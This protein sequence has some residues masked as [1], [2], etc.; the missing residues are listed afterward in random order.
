MNYRVVIIIFIIISICIIK[1]F[2]TIETFN[3]YNKPDP[4]R[5]VVLERTTTTETTTTETLSTYDGDFVVRFTGIKFASL[6]TPNDEYI[7]GDVFI[8]NLSIRNIDFM[9]V[10][11]RI[12]GDLNIDNNSELTN[13]DGL[14]N[15][16]YIGGS[17]NIHSNGE[18]GN[19]VPQNIFDATENCIA[20]CTPQT[21]STPH[22]SRQMFMCWTDE[23]NVSSIKS[24]TL[25]GTSNNMVGKAVI[26]TSKW[27]NIG[28]TL[29]CKFVNH[30]DTLKSLFVTSVKNDIQPYVN[31]DIH[32]FNSENEELF[33]EGNDATISKD[34]NFEYDIYIYFNNVYLDVFRSPIGIDCI[35]STHP[36]PIPENTV[37]PFR[38]IEISSNLASYSDNSQSGTASYEDNFQSGTILHEFMHALGFKHEQH[39]RKE[40]PDLT[41]NDNV[42]FNHYRTRMR[43]EFGDDVSD[44][45]VSDYVRSF[46]NT[47][48]LEV[49][50][51]EYSYEFQGQYDTSQIDLDSIMTYDIPL[52]FTCNQ[53]SCDDTDNN[54][55][56]FEE[57]EYGGSCDGYLMTTNNIL[58]YTDK[59][60]LTKIY[61]NNDS[62]QY[63]TSQPDGF[64]GS[65][66]ES[67]GFTYNYINEADTTQTTTDEYEIEEYLKCYY[68]D[69]CGTPLQI[70][71][72][73]PHSPI[74]DYI[75]FYDDI[76]ESYNDNK[77]IIFSKYTDRNTIERQDTDVRSI[78]IDLNDYDAVLLCC[79]KPRTPVIDQIKK[80][81]NHQD[82]IPGLVETSWYY[83]GD[84]DENWDNKSDNEKNN[85][86]FLNINTTES[87]NNNDFT[88]NENGEQVNIDDCN[89]TYEDD[90]NFGYYSFRVEDVPISNPAVHSYCGDDPEPFI[91]TANE[92]HYQSN[93]SNNKD[94]IHF[95]KL[96]D[97]SFRI[98]D[99]S[100]ITA[101]TETPPTETP[102]EKIFQNNILLECDKDICNNINLHIA[103][104]INYIRF[105]ETGDNEVNFRNT[106]NTPTLPTLSTITGCSDNDEWRSTF[107]KGCDKYDS[108]DCVWWRKGYINNVLIPIDEACPLTCNTCP[109]T[110]AP[111]E[112][113][114]E[115]PTEDIPI[116]DLDAEDIPIIDL[117]IEDLEIPDV[118]NIILT[119][120]YKSDNRFITNESERLEYENDVIILINNICDLSTN[121]SHFLFFPP[122]DLLGQHY[123]S[124]TLTE[125]QYN[126]INNEQEIPYSSTDMSYRLYSKHITTTPPATTTQTP[127]PID[128]KHVFLNF[129]PLFP[130]NLMSINTVGDYVLAN[131]LN[132]VSN[133]NRK[134]YLIIGQIIEDWGMLDI[135][136]YNN[137]YKHNKKCRHTRHLK[138]RIEKIKIHNPNWELV[139]IYDNQRKYINGENIQY[140]YE[141]NN[142]EYSLVNKNNANNYEL[143]PNKGYWVK[144]N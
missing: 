102:I 90:T 93:S 20:G 50:H 25:S 2:N 98:T 99:T 108:D 68:N 63:G 8:Q 114:T 79:S 75:N 36:P 136:Q 105:P 19:I 125:S 32:F 66:G 89:T 35:G 7:T 113:T 51:D 23:S 73:L 91:L 24:R 58:S 80:M 97:T 130:T 81:F 119:G 3:K 59:A 100:I 70:T 141:Y 11:K 106:L 4:D 71:T 28:Q 103:N 52:I 29:N 104:I 9:S 126:K 57:G 85:N 120:Q 139:S 132:W 92:Y 6:E 115:A 44:D 27:W 72:Q 1:S 39:N 74:I 60:F 53:N 13:L 31:L 78:D 30:H 41:L 37:Q 38:G 107:N 76:E 83:P 16:T 65:L 122:H 134:R 117:D 123:Y 45:D 67:T 54:C 14:S 133:G 137:G 12:G 15:I 116:I 40:H 135:R 142:G 43:N 96:N 18:G 144:Y 88:K 110:E 131:S 5:K 56:N 87:S 62:S 94:N 17:V 127:Q 69:D 47:N 10:V 34:D 121:R 118:D 77:K 82:V 86:K 33:I 124:I 129:N 64:R 140:I 42:I 22:I 128:R 46:I 21:T 109:T 84:D 111:T 49:H 112:T 55:Y 48:I 61:P 138:E 26:D 101:E 95:S 143:E